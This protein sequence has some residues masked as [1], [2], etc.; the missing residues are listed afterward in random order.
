MKSNK[1]VKSTIEHHYNKGKTNGFLSIFEGGAII[2]GWTGWGP[3]DYCDFSEDAQ[4]G[5]ISLDGN[6]DLIATAKG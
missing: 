5:V 1:Q 2:W 6:G 4:L 3:D